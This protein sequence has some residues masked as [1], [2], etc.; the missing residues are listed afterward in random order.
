MTL[1]LAWDVCAGLSMDCLLLEVVEA[2]CHVFRQS[3]MACVRSL[4]ECLIAVVASE[5]VCMEAVRLMV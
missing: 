5:Q 1:M 4:A 3:P 2:L